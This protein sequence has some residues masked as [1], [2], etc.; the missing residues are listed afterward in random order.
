VRPERRNRSRV[1]VSTSSGSSDPGAEAL[2]LLGYLALALVFTWP[3]A[4]HVT[5]HVTSA[6][7]DS[8]V[9]VWSFWWLRQALASPDLHFLHTDRILHPLGTDLV[10]NAGVWLL[11]LLTLPFQLTLGLPFAHNVAVLAAPVLSAF[12]MHR[13]GL[14]LTGD[15]L[16]SSVMG[17]LFGFSPFVV[18]RITGHLNIASVESVPFY[19]LALHRSLHEEGLGRRLA[20]GLWLAAAGYTDYLHLFSSLLFTAGLAF[21]YRRA[22]PLRGQLPKLLQIG[23]VFTAAFGPV[24]LALARLAARGEG[25]V[26]G[27]MGADGY[28][29]DLLSYVSPAPASTLLGRFSLSELFTGNPM[30]STTFLGFTLIALAALSLRR[31]WRGTGPDAAIVRTYAGIGLAFLV[32]SLGPFL[33]VAGREE[34]EIA[35]LELRL[36]LPW[37]LT[38][39]VPL[40]GNL[41]AP[42]RISIGVALCAVVMAG[43]ELRALFARWPGMRR[44][45]ALAVATLAAAESLSLPYPVEPLVIESALLRQVAEDPR[46]VAVLQL[47]FGIRSGFRA[48]GDEHTRQLYFQLLMRKKILGGFVTRIED[49]VLDYFSS[50][51]GI[52]HLVAIQVGEAISRQEIEGEALRARGAVSALGLGYVMLYKP[53]LRAGSEAAFRDFVEGV[54]PIERRQEDE[55]FVLYTLAGGDAPLEVPSRAR[56]QTTSRGDL[57]PGPS[58]TP[59]CGRRPA[60]R[61][62]TGEEGTCP[63]PPEASRRSARS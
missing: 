43:F 49:R 26:S 10:L 15:R 1:P 34:L 48:Y 40:L 58:T 60:P 17:L 37:W 19:L 41:R 6:E 30:E 57:A 51:P 14:Y 39:P 32:L 50:L 2:L 3:L 31:S 61:A 28:C 54:F 63:G 22:L 46:D 8:S 35:G 53:W 20:A 16:A 38:R 13:L 24:L 62:A 29:A 12:G 42:A 9:Y 56:D 7:G 25:R 59:A 47:P 44:R 36:P 21:F 52:A 33:H 55:H 11:G 4:L 45:I 5:T 18:T 27:W 23:G